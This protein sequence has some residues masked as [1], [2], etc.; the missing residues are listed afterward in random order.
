MTRELKFRGWDK[1]TKQM[2]N[3][4]QD[5]YD[6]SFNVNPSEDL[7]YTYCCF[8][9]M[10]DNP[11]YVH[12]MQYTGLKDK[13]GVE[14]YQDDCIRFRERIYRIKWDRY[15][16]QFF[17]KKGGMPVSQI[18]NHLDEAEVIGNIYQHGHLI[19]NTDTKI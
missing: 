10:I 1:E 9:S 17:N 13:N 6:G 3:D 14:I 8:G 19:D 7:N 2:I 12:I 4:V 5:V 16:W 15:K 11:E 18:V